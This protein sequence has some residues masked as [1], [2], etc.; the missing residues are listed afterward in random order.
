MK[1]YRVI[2]QGVRGGVYRRVSGSKSKYLKGCNLR[3]CRLEFWEKRVR[4]EEGEERGNKIM[5]G[6]L[7]LQ[8][9]YGRSALRTLEKE[10]REKKRNPTFYRLGMI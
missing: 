5:R 7:R 1:T 10:E 9:N 6:F 2:L 3:R 4:C 8:N